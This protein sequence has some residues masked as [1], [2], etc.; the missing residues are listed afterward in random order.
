M[1]MEKIKF[2]QQINAPREKVWEVL[3]NDA[4]Y[5]KWTS[6]FSS[7]SHAQSDWKE[8]SK[9]HFLDGKGMGMYSIIETKI[10]NTQMTFKHLGE[11]KNG[12]E[13]PV[14]TD[15]ENARESYFLEEKNG[16]TELR[17][18]L[19]SVG[20]FKDYFN[21]TFPKALNLVKELAEKQ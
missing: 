10:G 4:T 19:D 3:W 9:I 17:V 18:E 20:E 21:D 13:A 6:V 12:A 8:G 5:R 14:K 11:I 7:D 1:I 15:W 16:G 2:T